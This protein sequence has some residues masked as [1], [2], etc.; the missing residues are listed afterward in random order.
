MGADLN[1]VMKFLAS[2]TIILSLPTMAAGIYGMNVDRP[3]QRSQWAFGLVMG[4]A[5]LAARL[6]TWLFRRCDWL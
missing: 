3:F 5:L 6:I 4:V 1:V 2:V